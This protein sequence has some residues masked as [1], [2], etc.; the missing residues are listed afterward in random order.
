MIKKL[1][2]KFAIHTM[3]TL[4]ALVLCYHGLIMSGLI[5][6]QVAWGG[7]I[8]TTSQM[9]AF[10]AVSIL[11]NLLIMFLILLKASYIKIKISIRVLNIF[12]WIV[13]GI[14]ALNT[15]GNLLSTNFLELII[16]TPL[17]LMSA[18]L[19]YRMVIEKNAINL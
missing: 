7:R 13:I 18:I 6:Y 5:S 4:L 15:I 11:V 1:N 3:L 17:T 19:C 8:E 14:F 2:L 12:L 10:E 16:F 9:Y